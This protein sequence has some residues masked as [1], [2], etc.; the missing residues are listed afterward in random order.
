[1]HSHHKDPDNL[2]R[3]LGMGPFP[4]FATDFEHHT[5]FFYSFVFNYQ[6]LPTPDGELNEMT[7]RLGI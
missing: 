1:V 7:I 2:T 4:S 6:V 3:Q 5:F